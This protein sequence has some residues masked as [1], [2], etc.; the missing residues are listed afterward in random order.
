MTDCAAINWLMSYKGHNHAVI[1][2]QLELL[3]IAVRPGKMLEDA[4]YFSRLGEDV[5]ID[6]LLKDYLSFGRQ[7]YT[8]NP[9]DKGE[10]TPDNLPGC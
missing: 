6:P 9:T 10:I 1:R 4:N 3:T 2:L 7:L 5:H 8:N